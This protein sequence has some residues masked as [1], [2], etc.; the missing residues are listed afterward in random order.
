M[1]HFRNYPSNYILFN[2]FSHIIALVIMLPATICAGMTLPILTYYLVSNQYREDSIGKVY[3]AN[4]LGSIIGIILAVQLMPL[5]G[6]KNLLALGAGLDIILGLGLFLYA[7]KKFSRKSWII[8]TTISF[9]LFNLY[10]SLVQLDPLKLASG[11]F[12]EKKTF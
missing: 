11:V 9:V 6:L 8:I 12:R 7:M 5:L 4:T 3:A 2:L 10:V 1:L